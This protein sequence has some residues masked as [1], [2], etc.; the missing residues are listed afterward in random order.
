MATNGRCTFRGRGELEG[1]EVVGRVS[2]LAGE[3]LTLQLYGMSTFVKAFCPGE[4]SDS[5][6]KTAQKGFCQFV[7]RASDIW[8]R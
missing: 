7:Q 6:H 4:L 5:S 1:G 3:C 2:R 8:V